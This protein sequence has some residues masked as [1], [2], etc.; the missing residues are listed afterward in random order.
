[1]DDQPRVN[2]PLE[3]QLRPDRAFT[4]AL[5][6]PDTVEPLV[7]DLAALGT[8]VSEVRVLHG[9]DGVEAFDYEGEQHGWFAH[10]VRSLKNVGGADSTILF[11]YQEALQQ[12]QAIGLVPLGDLDFDA[13]VDVLRRHRAHHISWFTRGSMETIPTRA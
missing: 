10:L 3:R 5:G 1:M 13:V 4:F 8:D 12:G 2:E 9:P 11:A 6:G 7:A